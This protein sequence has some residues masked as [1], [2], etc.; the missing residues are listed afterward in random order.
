M[1]R[2][3]FTWSSSSRCCHTRLICQ[4]FYRSS[5]F[6]FIY[7][8]LLSPPSSCVLHTYATLPLSYFYPY[9]L[10]DKL[11]SLLIISSFLCTTHLP[12]LLLFTLLSLFYI[13]LSYFSTFPSLFVLLSP[14]YR[15]LSF[16][17]SILISSFS[18]HSS[19]FPPYLPRFLSLPVSSPSRLFRVSCLPSV[20]SFSSL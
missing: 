11:P 6:Y 3:C 12:S 13:L 1:L 20:L 18:S 7:Y 8:Y 16:F 5:S 14:D 9:S 15:Y 10:F 19:D 2:K 4:A 17:F